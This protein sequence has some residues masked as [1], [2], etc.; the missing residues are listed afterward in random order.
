MADDNEASEVSR[1]GKIQT[2]LMLRSVGVQLKHEDKIEERDI[3][4][5][6]A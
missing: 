2:G 5:S 1:L 6:Y 4:V 3:I